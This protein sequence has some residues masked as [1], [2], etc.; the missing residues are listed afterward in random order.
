MIASIYLACGLGLGVRGKDSHAPIDIGFRLFPGQAET[1]SEDGIETVAF[2]GYSPDLEFG[3]DWGITEVDL[4]DL[5]V[6]LTDLIDIEQFLF[7]FCQS[8]DDGFIFLDEDI[9]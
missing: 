5:D 2:V 7:D 8:E 9:P 6:I 4:G 1:R 3:D